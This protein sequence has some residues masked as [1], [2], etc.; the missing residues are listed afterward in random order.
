M[1]SRVSRPILAGLEA[2]ADDHPA[3]NPARTGSAG[4]GLKAYDHDRNSGCAKSQI[5]TKILRCGLSG[6]RT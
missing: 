6:G 3:G 4:R 2:K 5:E 1:L